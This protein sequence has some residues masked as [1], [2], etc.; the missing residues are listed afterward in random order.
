MSSVCICV[1]VRVCVGGANR[2]TNLLKML[3]GDSFVEIVWSLG[4][5]QTVS[6]F[7]FVGRCQGFSTMWGTLVLAT[8]NMAASAIVLA[9]SCPMAPLFDRSSSTTF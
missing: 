6:L 4:R 3:K 9:A 7:P 8:S 5:E 1:F 2:K